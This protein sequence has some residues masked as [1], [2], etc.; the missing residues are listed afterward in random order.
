MPRLF[1]SVESRWY[2]LEGI[3]CRLNKNEKLEPVSKDVSVITGNGFT[4]YTD[5]VLLANFSMP[6]SGELCADFGTGCGAIPMIWCARSQPQKVYAVEIQQCAC[7]MA[8]RS[9]EMNGF[10]NKIQVLECDIKELHE[11][12][13][14]PYGLDRIVCNPPYHE[15]GAGLHGRSA[16]RQAAFHETACTFSDIAAAAAAFLRCGGRFFCCMRPERLCGTLFSLHAAGLE[17]KRICFVQQRESSAPS[18]FLLQ[19][20]RGGKPGIKA[21]PVLIMENKDG[22][23]SEEM[24][25]IYGDYGQNREG[26]G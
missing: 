20:V 2:R 16:E 21:E 19:A 5:T 4:F 22:G 17:P 6:E 24:R 3:S 26:E 9:A 23:V 10:E 1:F 18:L 11:K 13:A 14:I 15:A 12:S 8:R 25:S 7:S